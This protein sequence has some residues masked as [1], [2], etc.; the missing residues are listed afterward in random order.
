M[1]PALTEIVFALGQGERVVGV[2]AFSN[3]PPDVRKLP[4][5]GGLIDPNFE[6]LSQ[7]QPDLILIQGLNQKVEEW[8]RATGQRFLSVNLDSLHDVMQ[9]PRLLGKALGCPGAGT[10]LAARMKRELDSI[11]HKT[12]ERRKVRVFLCLGRESAK[13]EGL[14]T[15][16]PGTFLHELLEVCGGQNVFADAGVP[17]PQPSLET[18]L[19]RRPEVVIEL[20][21]E[22]GAKPPLPSDARAAWS[23]LP[24]LPAVQAGRVFV[25][26]EDYALIPGPRITRLARRIAELL[27]PEVFPHG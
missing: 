4:E 16:G 15:A 3:Y 25:I 21:A 26:N 27:H 23:S 24:T 9:A 7:L 20:G 18:L 17:Y 1:S 10:E 6:V 22:M 2:S 12:R 5:C 14:L 19:Q 11:A 13:L 8:C